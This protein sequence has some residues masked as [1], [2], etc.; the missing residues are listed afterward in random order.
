MSILVPAQDPSSVQV[1]LSLQVV[2]CTAVDPRELEVDPPGF[3]SGDFA[4]WVDTRKDELVFFPT[5][6][7]DSPS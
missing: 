4:A 2:R 7:N 1:D 6:N 5:R 3:H